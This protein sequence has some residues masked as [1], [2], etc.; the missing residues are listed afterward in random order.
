MEILNQ[1]K[2][3]GF[4]RAMLGYRNMSQTELAEA[5]GLHRSIINQF[6]RRKVNLLPADIDKIFSVLEAEDY[7]ERLNL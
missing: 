3:A 4:V 1:D 6:C 2:I 7:A 5:T